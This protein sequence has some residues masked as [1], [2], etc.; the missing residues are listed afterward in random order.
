MVE[1]FYDSTAWVAGRSP[2]ADEACSVASLLFL[3]KYLKDNPPQRTVILVATSGHAQALAGMRDLVWSFTTRSTI[4]RQMARD[5]K[6]LIN[7][8]RKTIKAL[9]QSSFE[10]ANTQPLVDKDAQE[11]K[12]TNSMHTESFLSMYGNG[13]MWG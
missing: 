10:H 8:A 2:G 5:L 3:A 4:Q 1:A 9:E 11:V 7:K 6:A 13:I 12:N